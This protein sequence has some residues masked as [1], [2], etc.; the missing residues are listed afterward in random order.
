MLTTTIEEA[1]SRAEIHVEIAYR[2]AIK[3]LYDDEYPS[4]WLTTIYT[5]E[6]LGLVDPV[7]T[8]ARTNEIRF[9]RRRHFQRLSEQAHAKHLAA[10]KQA[11]A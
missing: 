1:R 2:R 9:L 4:Y 8:A 6:A 5:V 7:L 3:D 10:S 11:R